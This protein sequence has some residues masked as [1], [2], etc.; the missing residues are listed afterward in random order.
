[1]FVAVAG[2]LAMVA[3][4]GYVA[5]RLR[6]RSAMHQEIRDIMSQYMPLE[7]NER[8]A[9]AAGQQNSSAPARPPPAE[10]A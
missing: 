6:I 7:S 10:E 8:E 2:A 5:Y 9:L 3:A 4:A 1:M